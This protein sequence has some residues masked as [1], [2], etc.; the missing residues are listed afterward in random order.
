[1]DINILRFRRNVQA[2]IQKSFSGGRLDIQK[3][4]NDEFFEGISDDFEKAHH[5]VGDRHPNGKWVW[6]EYKPGKFDWRGVKTP[7]GKEA[8]E[9]TEQRVPEKKESASQSTSAEKNTVNPNSSVKVAFNSSEA[10]DKL[11]TIKDPNF[12]VVKITYKGKPIGY[13][14][15]LQTPRH[16]Y[17]SKHLKDLNDVISKVGLSSDDFKKYREDAMNGDH[18]DQWIDTSDKWGSI[19]SNGKGKDLVTFNIIWDKKAAE[20]K[21]KED[22]DNVA[23]KVS[24]VKTTISKENIATNKPLDDKC[25]K[26]FYYTDA[27]ADCDY[28]NNVANRCNSAAWQSEFGNKVIVEGTPEE[29]VSGK[30]KAIKVYFESLNDQFDKAAQKD[31][32]Y[33]INHGPG[34]NSYWM[35]YRVSDLKRKVID[36]KPYFVATVATYKGLQKAI[37]DHEDRE[38]KQKKEDEARSIAADKAYKEKLAHVA[39]ENKKTAGKKFTF[40]F[41]DEDKISDKLDHIGSENTT[42]PQGTALGVLVGDDDVK[43]LEDLTNEEKSFLTQL[44]EQHAK[45]GNYF[46][47]K[48]E[49]SLN[50][51][52]DKQHQKG[53]KVY[54]FSAGGDGTYTVLLKPKKTARK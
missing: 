7:V 42:S 47:W 26:L 35:S 33:L 11:A 32:R 3:A 43:D 51:Y 2:N 13:Q 40:N 52:V 50:K 9:K 21:K 4:M 8:L 28:W 22:E 37:K 30:K 54:Q 36:G 34:T 53:Y 12:K 23:S 25:K 10:Y 14:L 5:N 27:K 46:D 17:I 49:A 38:A 1:M 19:K 20:A 24:E 41:D 44:K 45:P 6:T 29:L 16:V 18:G 48:D 15:T 31:V 39:E